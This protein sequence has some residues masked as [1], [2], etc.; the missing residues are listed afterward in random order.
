[1]SGR[2]LLGVNQRTVTKRWLTV[3]IAFSALRTLYFA[4]R[5]LYFA[6]PTPLFAPCSPL[7]AKRHQPSAARP[8]WPF[9]QCP[10]D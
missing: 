10:Y 7:K 6:L 5:T 8:G 1:M 3:G 2:V 9:F 4:L